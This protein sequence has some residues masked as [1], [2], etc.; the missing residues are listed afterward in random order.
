[1]IPKCISEL[2]VVV[3]VLNQCLDAQVDQLK[4]NRL[5]LHPGMMEVLWMSGPS[6]WEVDQLPAPNWVAL[7]LKE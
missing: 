4:A 5:S 2:E 3:Q 6:I 1:M 7:S